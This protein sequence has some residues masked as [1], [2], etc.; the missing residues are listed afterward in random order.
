MG[1]FTNQLRIGRQVWT[2]H[3]RIPWG[4]ALG[5]LLLFLI[6]APVLLAAAMS[7]IYPRPPKLL[8][9]PLAA[10]MFLAPCAAAAID[11]RWRRQ[12]QGIGRLRRWCSPFEGGT[13]FMA[14][15]WLIAVGLFLLM[16]YSS[17]R[18]MH[19]RLPQHRIKPPASLLTHAGQFIST[20]TPP[21][22]LEK[23]R[24]RMPLL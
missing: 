8:F 12:Q 1:R 4:N 3:V 16:C 7:S 9:V 24:R 10:L 21:A 6:I 2:R 11:I 23:R 22:E 5:V 18:A 19:Q 13:V 15:I 20:S 17:F 14:P